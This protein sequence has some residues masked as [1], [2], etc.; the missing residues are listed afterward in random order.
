M[1]GR[2]ENSAEMTIVPDI[3]ARVLGTAMPQTGIPP[4]HLRK[5]AIMFSD[6]LITVRS[7][8]HLSD[9]VALKKMLESAGFSRVVTWYQV[10]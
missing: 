3:A 1:W 10:C 2:K 6:G 9:S 8:F 4:R 7:A 5:T